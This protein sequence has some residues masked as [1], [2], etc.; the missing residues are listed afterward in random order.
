MGAEANELEIESNF[1]KT[2]ANNEG[3]ATSGVSVGALRS[4]LRRECNKTINSDDGTGDIVANEECVPFGGSIVAL[5]DPGELYLV[6]AA[7]S[8]APASSID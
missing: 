4:K 8:N 6:K 2:P 3:A 5:C 1:N 7:P